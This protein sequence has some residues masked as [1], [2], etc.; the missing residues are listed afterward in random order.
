MPAL[1]FAMKTEEYMSERSRIAQQ[2]FDLALPVVE[3]LGFDLVDAEYKKE[4]TSYFLRLFIDKRGG[5]GI[6]D[7]E[8]VSKAV[9]PIFDRELHA[10]PDYFEVSSPGLTRPLSSPSD[11]RR[12]EG[13][14][15]EMSFYMA[16]NGTKHL[17]GIIKAVLDDKLLLESEGV[18]CE[19]PF[20]TIASAKRTIR[21]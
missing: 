19:V 10:D 12:H 18:T 13:E 16:V 15:V 1:S 11:F 3:G 9:D 2:A 21:F 4:G 5:I 8:L 7:C 6:D 14:E 17:T 20:D